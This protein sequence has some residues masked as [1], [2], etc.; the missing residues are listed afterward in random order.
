MLA[1]DMGPATT[2]QLIGDVREGWKAGKLNETPDI[3]PFLKQK[4][5]AYWPDDARSLR[6][7]RHDHPVMGDNTL[8]VYQ[9]IG[10]ALVAARDQRQRDGGDQRE[11]NKASTRH[12]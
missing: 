3:I 5:V 7:L 8:C 6:F 2:R 11:T 1:A 9:H 10:D 4:I 12:E